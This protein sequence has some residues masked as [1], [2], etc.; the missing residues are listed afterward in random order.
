V[1]ALVTPEIGNGPL[2]IMLGGSGWS[3]A[4]I[5]P[6]TRAGTDGERLRVGGLEIDLGEAEVWEPRPGW[7][8]LRTRRAAI[9]AQLP[10]LRALGLRQARSGSFLTLLDEIPPENQPRETVL[11][12]ARS[13]VH[14]L[15]EGWA[16]D[17][18][19]VQE[20]AAQL[21]GLGG[22][23]TPGGDDFLCGAMLWAWLTHPR[24]GS[25]CHAIAE[26]TTPRTT[27]LSAA[28]LWAAAQGECSAA[29]HAL[30]DMLRRGDAVEIARAADEVLAHGATSGADAL[31]GFLWAGMEFSPQRGSARSDGSGSR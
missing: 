6:G 11:A 9:E 3:L 10:A 25:F 4:A 17:L 14:A 13:A 2:N 8:A 20:G 7:A 29:W 27:T 31:A 19:W 18:A 16:G 23:L 5:E 15:E 21:A 12:A 30:F 22:G 28:L 1:V 26:A 24:P